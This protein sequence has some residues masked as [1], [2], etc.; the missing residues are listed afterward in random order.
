MNII[1]DLE[2][3]IKSLIS[4]IEQ[5]TKQI[6][7]DDS[8]E[9]KLSLILRASA[10]LSIEKNNFLLR[11]YQQ[12]LKKMRAKDIQSVLNEE[13]L[14]E[15]IIENNYF[16]YQG[17]RIKRYPKKSSKEI[18]DA[19]I[20]MDELPEDFK[21]EDIDIFEIGHKSR[22]L[23]LEIHSDLDDDL[24]EIK[25]EFLEL[26]ENQFDNTNIELKLLN[27][28]IPILILQLKVLLKNIRENIEDDHLNTFKGF[29]KFED[30]WINELWISHQ[31]YMG[32]F[33]WKEII[34]DMFVTSEQKKS[35]EMVFKNWI[36]VKKIL[37]DKGESAYIYNNVFDQ[38]I[39]KYAEL[40]DENDESN[41]EALKQ[42]ITNIT[43]KENF[44][45][46][47][48]EHNIITPYMKFKMDKEQDKVKKD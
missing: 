16:K 25:N 37:N 23:F 31:A 41:L 19:L 33:K 32:F 14:K 22:E 46:V 34:L 3:R 45:S 12:K 40:E 8:G 43:K 27:Y 7:D 20:I 13:K 39:L 9:K 38:M 30:W 36:L 48:A 6:N 1:E 10:E 5:S 18:E 24:I 11:K 35:F 47:S 44:I 15:E 2:K 21:L 4:H 29:P 42:I 28:R 17:L 26:V